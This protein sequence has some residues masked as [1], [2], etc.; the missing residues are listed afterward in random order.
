MYQRA[1]P[2]CMTATKHDAVGLNSSGPLK[3]RKQATSTHVAILTMWQ[4]WATHENK[5]KKTIRMSIQ[6]N[7]SGS[8]EALQ[9]PAAISF[10]C[11]GLII[12]TPLSLSLSLSIFYI[13]MCVCGW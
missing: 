3:Q 11:H 12:C 7:H 9:L 5:K 13:C 2:Y 10:K 6:S 1:P 4:N 8:F